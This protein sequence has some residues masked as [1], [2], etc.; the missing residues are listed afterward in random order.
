VGKFGPAAA[1]AAVGMCI[2]MCGQPGDKRSGETVSY[3]GLQM[4]VRSGKSNVIYWSAPEPSTDSVK[5]YELYYHGEQTSGWTLLKGN[6]PPATNP[7]VTVQRDSLPAAD[8]VF[9]FS[10]KYY[11]KSGASSSLHSSTDSTA[12]PAGGW[13]MFWKK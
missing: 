6:I 11:T 4:E 2:M 7:E 3:N 5:Y 9:F 12:S 8:S 10:V 1:I 13:F